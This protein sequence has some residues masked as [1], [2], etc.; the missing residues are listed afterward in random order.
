MQGRV[1]GVCMTLD[2]FDAFILDMDGTLVDT[3]KFHARAFAD[4]VL[5][6]SGYVLLP[7]EHHEFF[8]SHSVPFARVLNQRY[9]LSLDPEKV[10]K[11]KRRRMDEIFVA[12]LFEGAREFLDRWYGVRPMALAT[13]SPR[14]FALPTLEAVGIKSFFEHIITTDDVENRKPDPEMIDLSIHKLQTKPEKTLVFEDQLLGVE[15]A[16]SAGAS[17]VAVDNGQAVEFPPDVPVATWKEWLN[18]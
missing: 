8:A 17:V 16:R 18:A 12:E 5:D 10:L 9:G 1:T 11:Q 13:N 6:Q 2:E 4:A 3:G 15:A 14:R 7:H